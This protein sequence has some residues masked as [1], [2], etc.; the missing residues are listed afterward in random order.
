MQADGC[1]ATRR[2]NLV[3]LHDYRTNRHLTARP[4][5]LRFTERQ[6]HEF[7]VGWHARSYS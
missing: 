1:I 2:Y 5:A 7:D 3:I 4:G 6:A